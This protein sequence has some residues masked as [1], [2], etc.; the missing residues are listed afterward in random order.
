MKGTA[1]R[2]P[3]L[4]ALAVFASA[5]SAVAATKWP[6]F[7]FDSQHSG[8]NTQESMIDRTSVS[9]LAFRYQ[10]SLP[11]VADG[12]PA[13]LPG[14][15]T[16]QGTLDLLFLTTKAGHL[17]A[18]DA[19]TGSIVWSHQNAAGSCKIN[20]G[21]NTCYTTLSPAVDPSGSFVYGYGLDGKVHKYAVGDGAETTTGGWPETATLKGFDEKGSSALSIAVAQDGHARLYV[22]NGGY[23]GDNGDYQGHVT[24]IDLASGSQNVFNANCSDQAV[25]FVTTPGTPDCAAVQTAVWARAGIVYEPSLNRIFFG[26]GNGA[27]D[28]Q[29]VSA[30]NH[31]WGDSVLAIHPDG[32]G[33]SGNPLDS[34][35]PADFQQLDNQDL[36]LGSTAPAILPSAFAGGPLAVQSGKDSNVRLLNLANLSG[37]GGVA[38]L[39]GEL[40]VVPVTQG[41]EVLTHPAVW[42]NPVDQSTWFFVANGN[43]ISGFKL[44]IDGLGNP[45]IASQWEKAGG[46]TSPILANGVLFYAGSGVLRALNP[47]TGAVLWSSTQISGIHW[48]SPIVVDGSVYVTD[49]SLHLTAFALPAGPGGPPNVDSFT[50]T[51]SVLGSAGASTLAWATS[52]STSVTISG[53]AGSFSPSG[54]HGVS[55]GSTTSYTLTATGAGGSASAVVTVNVLAPGGA[56]LASPVISAPTAGQVLGATNVGFSWGSVA[57]ANGYGFRIFNASNGQT[58]FTG[59]SSGSGATSTAVGLPGGAQAFAVRACAGGFSDASCGPYATV[60][61]SVHVNAPS[62]SQTKFFTLTPC[63]VADTRNAA[64][65]FGGPA[66]AAET[67]RVFVLAGHCGIPAGAK[68]VSLNLTVVTPSTSGSLKINPTGVDP[69]PASANV[70]AAGR[71]LAN[72]AISFLGADGAMVVLDAQITGVVDLVIDA[73]GYFQ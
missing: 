16:S 24:A 43:G 58:E 68:A 56:A 37:H 29:N 60:N 1:G 51:P 26:T 32:T 25:H 11:S 69:G 46:G 13:Y 14:V 52:R 41:G 5:A 39:G 45:S 23:P 49:E 48:E 28:A 59:T 64:G 21:S 63:R 47:E 4:F 35:T 67:G 17:L 20:N 18:V 33:S 40:Q 73:N 2:F 70:F 66:L 61:F 6:Q 36:D 65:P 38:H 62:S 12:A 57:G 71:T 19:A 34:Y 42:V 22:T 8:N 50:A 9:N 44:T 27:F 53:V 3:F 55:V 31:D 30:P 7:D 72:N 54:S 10:V 15:S